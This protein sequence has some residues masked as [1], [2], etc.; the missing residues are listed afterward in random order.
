MG[1]AT[2][3]DD[4]SEFRIPLALVCRRMVCRRAPFLSCALTKT[5]VGESAL[6]TEAE[7]AAR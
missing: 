7:E 5:R 4:R 2:R 6:V 3:V 1:S